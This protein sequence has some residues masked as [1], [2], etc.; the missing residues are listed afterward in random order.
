V[1]VF[2]AMA[3]MLTMPITTGNSYWG[4]ASAATETPD[5]IPQPVDSLYFDILA[6]NLTIKGA[7]TTTNDDNSAISLDGQN[8]YLVLDSAL[9]EKL[10]AFTV[11]AWVNPDYKKG[12]PATL[13][14]VSEANAFELAINNDK[15]D[16]NV[17]MFSVYDG[18]KWHTVQ[19]RSAI[20]EAWTHISATYSDEQIRIF[21]NGVQEGSVNISGDY[22]LTHQYGESSQNSYDY[23]SLQTDVLIGAFNPN[24]RDN[25]SFANHFSG[26]IDDVTLYDKQLTSSQISS[27]DKSERTPDTI[28]E[29]E[30]QSVEAT[31]E[32]T[33]T[34]NEYG[35]VTSEDTSNDQKIE[36]VA[37]EGYK[38]KKPEETKKKDKANNPSEK[39]KEALEENPSTADQP[40]EET[41]DNTEETV[42]ENTIESA[43][44]SLPV[45]PVSEEILADD[46]ALLKKLVTVTN[47]TDATFSDLPEIESRVQYQWKLFGE[48]DGNLVDLTNDPSV[49]LTLLDLDSNNKLDRAEWKTTEGVTEYYLV[50]SVILATD[51]LHLDEN[52]DY[53]DDIFYEIKQKDD[54]WTHEIPA[55]DFVRVTFETALDS[56][57]DISIFAKSSGTASINVFE[58]D[59]T[60]VIATFDSVTSEEFQS[61]FLTNLASPQDVFDLEIVGDSIQ[62]DLI[63]DP[64]TKINLEQCHNWDGVVVDCDDPAGPDNFWGTGNA[65][66]ANAR[67]GE[68]DSQNYRIIITDLPAA[69]DYVLVF[70]QDLTKQ[71]SMAQDFWTGPGNLPTANPPSLNNTGIHPCIDTKGNQDGYCDPLAEPFEVAIPFM[72]ETGDA[73]LD[74]ALGIAQEEHF[75]AIP[76]NQISQGMLIFTDSPIVESAVLTV[77]GFSGDI[78]SDSSIQGTLTFT[79][80]GTGNL[81]IVYGGHISATK[82]Y[83]AINKTTA[84]DIPGSP[85][86]NRLIS[87]TGINGD[88]GNQDMQL[89]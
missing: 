73:T 67:V 45:P 52:R 1:A 19:S 87:F 77:G 4:Y 31:A 74:M 6:D 60:E 2:F 24:A 7:L 66:S 84:V 25:A 18:I 85:Y 13:A 88:T 30:A 57:K 23:L 5:G 55:G 48:V 43:P 61:V 33:G 46:S 53:V 16:K 39:A 29:Q 15:V 41:V 49:D 76:A 38:V 72:N 28:P 70:E 9:S 54:V 58:K 51:G 3:S 32:Q 42:D 63:I 83:E 59:G 34:A 62:F 10:D 11:S 71:G 36:A 22:S 44:D 80:N 81:V 65:N 68:G 47:D 86:H 37:A 17:A 21:V 12:A 40:N 79:T 8:D 64:P 20:P 89:S 14:I 78:T 82:D 56:T 27:L 26:L 69:D 35:F 50:A 75:G